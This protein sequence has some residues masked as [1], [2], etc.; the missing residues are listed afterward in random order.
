MRQRSTCFAFVFFS[1]FSCSHLLFSQT[2]CPGCTLNLPP[3]LPEDTV[4]LPPVP[5][6][7]Q[8]V[9]YSQ[10]ISFRMPKSTT[11]VNAIDSTTPPNLPI[12]QIEILSLE[13]LP[14]GLHWQPNQF[15][16][17]TGN[18]ETDG[19]IRICGTPIT[20]DS[21]VLTVKLKATVFIIS[22]EASFP[23]HLYIAPKT[24]TTDG[25]SMTNVIG[26]GSTTVSFTNNIPSGGNPGFTYEWDF[27]D[28]STF[29]GENPPPHTYDAPGIY[30]VSYH[31]TIDTAPLMLVSATVLN[32]DC[33][34]LL[35]IGAPDLYLFIT[36]PSGGAQLFNSSPAIDNT[37]LP[38]TFPIGLPLGSG[39]YTLELWDDDAGIDGTDDLC[40][41]ISFNYLS[42]D[43]LVSG[44]MTIVLDIQHQ[45]EEVT[46]LDTVLVYPQ[47]VEP[48]VL[49]PNG[50]TT[51]AHSDTLIL[52]SS[53]GSGN[54]WWYN[55]APIQNANAFT[56]LPSEGGFYQV[57][58][59]TPYGCTAIS[60]SVF[61][62]FYDLPGL[63]A[64]ENYNNRLQV[65]DTAALPAQY[66]L[67]WYLNGAPIPG[68]TGLTYCA[69][70][71]GNYGLV[72][73]DLET[74]C[75][76]FFA[77]DI[78]IDPE[79]DCTVGTE[80]PTSL[81]VRLSIAP[82]PARDAAHLQWPAA[83]RSASDLRVFDARGGLLQRIRLE[84]GAT[85]YTLSC[86]NLDAGMYVIELG[87]VGAAK[88]IVLR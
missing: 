37:T 16:F 79:F 38:H 46:A 15:V 50:L 6:G 28:D 55:G 25:F 72:V 76:N 58:I 60:D 24:S 21:F 3:G 43:T 77:A 85:A 71:D 51:C 74:G 86:L 14:P 20:S 63:P 88:L 10:D 67:Q 27:G 19:C 7:E 9:A 61:V 70:V 17:Q 18:G 32:T 75:S 52:L 8:G 4:Y 31:A 65:I 81:P 36:G 34:D 1:F 5:D 23:M 42:N 69:Q 54:Q 53:S 87:G 64:Y 59:L 57:Q 13:G 84:S 41:V 39:N 56:Y 22:Q 40:G 62:G 12:S 11:P 33:S 68:E 73:T 47:P 48:H 44:N 49:S 66:G 35:G 26:C 82:N 2:G 83:L 29:V 78:V 45:V 80:T 30:P